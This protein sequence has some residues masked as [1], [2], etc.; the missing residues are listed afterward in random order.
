MD[1]F[2]SQSNC[3]RCGNSLTARTMSWFTEETIC[4]D[5]SKKEAEIKTA[6]RNAGDSRA[7]E[8]CE[9]LPKI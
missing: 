6:L 1:K 8:G 9:Y 3:D 2:F 4:M 5:C 7:M